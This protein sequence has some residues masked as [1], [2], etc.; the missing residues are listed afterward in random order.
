MALALNDTTETYPFNR[1]VKKED[2]LV[3]EMRN[4]D[5]VNPHT[6]TVSLSIEESQ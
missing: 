4:G 6:I 3:V 1:P 5:G 2:D